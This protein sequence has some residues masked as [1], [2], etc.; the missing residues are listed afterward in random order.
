MTYSGY[1][2]LMTNAV[3][4]CQWAMRERAQAAQKAQAARK[5]SVWRDLATVRS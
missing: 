2:E 1:I 3:A 5:P 4:E